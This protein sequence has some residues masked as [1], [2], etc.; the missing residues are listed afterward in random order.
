[1]DGM[2]VVLMPFLMFLAFF[3]LLLLHNQRQRNCPDCGQPLSFIQ[4]PCAKTRRMWFEG[5]Y[6]CR[7]CGCETTLGGEKVA[8]GTG[9]R[10]RSLVWRV[11]ILTLAVA[12]AGVQVFF[13]LSIRDAVPALPAPPAVLAPPPPLV[14]PLDAPPVR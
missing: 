13:L 9:P 14:A 3:V 4:S 11:S 8:P 1:M 6:L 12:V 2:I 10:T 5:G 7:N